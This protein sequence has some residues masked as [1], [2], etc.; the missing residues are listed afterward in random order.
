M[1]LN[2]SGEITAIATAALA[3]FAIVTAWYARRAFLKQSQEVSAIE[4]QV[5]DQEELTGQ[6]ARLLEVQSGQLELQR[7]QF[8]EQ[9][10][11]NAAY[12]EVL[13]LQAE[14]FRTSREQRGREAEEQRRRQASRVTAW[15]DT[16]ETP[17]GWVPGARVR[18]AS[19][20]PVYEVRVFFHLVHETDSSR[21]PV[22]QGGPP[23]RETTPV[24]PPEET[25][26]TRIP[27]KVEDMWGNIPVTR[28]PAG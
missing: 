10:Q 15:F 19:D 21:V 17:M 26:F 14:E 13:Q 16:G 8:D 18:N 25:V 4:R 28:G 6:Q 11:I 3:A 5:K 24:L 22:S 9:R 7:Q 2:L 12:G 1:S 20:E 23:P 27:P